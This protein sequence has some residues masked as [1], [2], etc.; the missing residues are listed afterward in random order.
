VTWY[1]FKES[2]TVII[3]A[4]GNLDEVSTSTHVYITILAKEKR[5]DIFSNSI[6]WIQK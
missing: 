2:E 5:R 3:H 1:A 4:L 6:S